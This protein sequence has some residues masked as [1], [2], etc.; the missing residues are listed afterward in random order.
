MLGRTIAAALFPLFLGGLFGCGSTTDAQDPC[1]CPAGST[2]RDGACVADCPVG[3]IRCGA[4]C[5]RNDTIENCGTCGHL[6]AST[7]LC[8]AGTCEARCDSPKTVCGTTCTD[9]AT[10]PAHCGSCDKACAT[11]M[12]CVGGACRWPG[13]NVKHVV[14]IVQENHSFDSYF[15]RYCQAKAGSE[16]TC[17]TGPDCCESPTKD[18]AGNYVDPTGA[19]AGDHTDSSNF[20]GDR[21]HDQV[22]ELDQIDGGK[23]DRFVSGMDSSTSS[24]LGVKGPKCAAAANWEMAKGQAAGDPAY[25]Y[26]QLAGSYALGDRY[27]QPIAG[28]TASNDMYL[29]AARFRFVD[30]DVLPGVAVG[31]SSKGLCLDPIGCITGKKQ[32]V[33]YADKTVA[34]L[35]TA[36]GHTFASYADGY[37]AAATAAAKGSCPSASAA[38]DCPYSNC[39][40]H[41]VACNGCLYDPSDQPFLYFAGFADKGGA[42]SPA[43]KDYAR[44]SEDLAS[45]TLPSFSYV[46]ARVFR[47]EHPNLSTITD[48][49]KFV[50]ATVDAIL[51]SKYR[52]DTLILLTWD[53][54]GGFFDHVA[55]PPAWPVTVDADAAG[56]PVPYG[57]RVPMLA[58]GRFAKKNH[59]SH[60]RTEH[61][62][63]VAFLEWNFL[64]P[65]QIGALGARDKVVAGLGDLLDA[66]EVGIAPP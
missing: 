23:M 2:C 8:A 35:L 63:I 51:A 43:V 15:G 50:K 32:A 40:T 19:K 55:P 7:E 42:P 54:G 65:E 27:F 39:L 4:Y 5:V 17:T 45:G 13:T 58:I 10:D 47:N 56:K 48:G 25:Y 14:L 30:N 21:N 52:D 18:A 46:K 6:C 60:R 1:A 28:G 57:T 26:W 61:S 36:A 11:G 38:S 31:T 12:Q 59:V 20:G 24:C 37:G 16:P 9:P 29:A 34:D 62:S 64:G 3:Q 41:P 33:P 22:C 53:E 49:V 44:L 66:A